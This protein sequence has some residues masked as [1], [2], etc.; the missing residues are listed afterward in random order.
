[1]EFHESLDMSPYASQSQGGGEYRLQSVLVHTGTAHGGHY[2]A[3]V[4]DSATGSWLDCNDAV[5]CE[6]K[7]SEIQALFWRDGSRPT[8]ASGQSGSTAA[9]KLDSLYENAYMLRYERVEDGSIPRTATT[10]WVRGQQKNHSTFTIPLAVLFFTNRL[11]TII[12]YIICPII[13]L[14]S[15]FI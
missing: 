8:S 7:E 5:V 3:Y 1:V 12:K 14:I 2:R 9:F 10:V 11:R 15:I 6:L 4:R 13:F